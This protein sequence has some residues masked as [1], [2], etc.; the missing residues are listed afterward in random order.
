MTRRVLAIDGGGCR[1]II[2]IIFL[3]SLE[4]RLGRSIHDVFDLY[5]GTSTGGII[6][7]LLATK[8]PLQDIYNFYTK[9]PIHKIFKGR[10]NINPLNAIKYPSQDIEGVLRDLFK[11]SKLKDI[12]PD[13]N[14]LI[15]SYDVLSKQAK[16]LTNTDVSCQE[17]LLSD[18]ARSTSAAPT[19]FE[20]YE[21]NGMLC[22]DG[23]LFA[24]NPAM[25]AYVEA[26]KIY[27][28]EDIIV[29]SLGT[30]SLY[31]YVK[32][33]KIKK[34]SMLDWA[35]NLFDL[36][37]DGQSDTTE[38]ILRKLL[39]RENYWRFQVRISASNAN[40][41]NVSDNNLNDLINITNSYINNDWRDS[42][43]DLVNIL[44]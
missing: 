22:L 13:K 20:P 7:L 8:V 18:I 17:M 19:F 35:S 32:P 26:K 6:S 34:Y 38:Y 24:N 21:N 4:K 40:M 12:S 1:G 27:P 15:T 41:D 5:S 37:S 11:Q 43:E 14:V 42:L 9:E 44:K 3:M 23:G 29:V 39:P 25:S 10:F 2:P 28:E 36:V 16:F 33:E 30:G 31:S